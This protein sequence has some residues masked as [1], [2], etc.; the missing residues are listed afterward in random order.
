MTLPF[1][2]SLTSAGISR[3]TNGVTQPRLH[4]RPR[5]N[6]PLSPAFQKYRLQ[7]RPS[8]TPGYRP[9]SLS[10]FPLCV[11]VSVRFGVNSWS[12]RDCVLVIVLR[13]RRH[14]FSTK[15]RA[16]GKNNRRLR[17]GHRPQSSTREA[18]FARELKSAQSHV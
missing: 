10:H 11:G 18:T 12:S 6:N 8:L 5:L 7:S 14:R 9:F 2:S 1:P 17:A 15:A 4:V 3:K 16:R 13:V